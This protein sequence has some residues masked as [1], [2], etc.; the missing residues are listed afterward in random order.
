MTSR[1]DDITRELALQLGAESV[2]IAAVLP[3]GDCLGC[4]AVLLPLD[5]PSL[6][7]LAFRA[8]ARHLRYCADRADLAARTL[9]KEIQ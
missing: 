7:A 4:N 3:N 2:N 8:L 1:L 6:R 9:E 5:A